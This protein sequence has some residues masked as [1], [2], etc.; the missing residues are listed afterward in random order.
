MA[1][2][3]SEPK[4]YRYLCRLTLG[5]PHQLSSLSN[6][7]INNASQSGCCEDQI[8][9]GIREHFV[10]NKALNKISSYLQEQRV[11]FHLPFK[12]ILSGHGIVKLISPSF[13]LR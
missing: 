3:V 4:S 2:G 6:E 9:E 8:R 5:R 7:D 10:H 13:A 1:F 12:F 11:K